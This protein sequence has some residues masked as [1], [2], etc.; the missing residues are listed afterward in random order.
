M[1]RGVKYLIRRFGCGAI[2][3]KIDC[4]R[5]QRDHFYGKTP[6]E[7]SLESEVSERKNSY[8]GMLC[9]FAP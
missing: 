2:R 9:G 1:N 7:I 4:P 5:W 6:E 3:E 8:K